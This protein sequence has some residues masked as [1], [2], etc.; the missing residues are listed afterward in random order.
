MSSQQSGMIIK[1]PKQWSNLHVYEC[2]IDG[3]LIIFFYTFSEMRWNAKRS[4]W[5]HF[6]CGAILWF[7][8]PILCLVG[9]TE[10]IQFWVRPV[11]L[12]ASLIEWDDSPLSFIY[13][14]SDQFIHQHPN[15][16]LDELSISPG[17]EKRAAK[18]QTKV[19]IQ[20]RKED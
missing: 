4:K 6:H 19:D 7:T 8:F 13:C 2:F 17:R 5:G 10:T 15:I 9:I 14:F 20:L 1:I 11:Q 16:L 18:N 12:P 3:K